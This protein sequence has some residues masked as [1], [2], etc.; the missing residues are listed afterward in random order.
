MKTCYEWTR[1]DNASALRSI[2]FQCHDRIDDSCLGVV[3]DVCG[4]ALFYPRS[5]V[6][7]NH[8]QLKEIAIFVCRLEKAT[9]ETK[10]RYIAWRDRIER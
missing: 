4:Q 8:D 3:L 10:A 1:Y 9:I 2:R 5:R 6:S 7:L